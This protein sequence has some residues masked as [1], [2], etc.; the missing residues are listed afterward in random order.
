MTSET[1]SGIINQFTLNKT[2]NLIDNHQI[3]GNYKS[4]LMDLGTR[5]EKLFPIIGNASVSKKDPLAGKTF[6]LAGSKYSEGR[7]FLFR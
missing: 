2:A 5:L 4:Y 7:A 3:A 1:I 6:Y